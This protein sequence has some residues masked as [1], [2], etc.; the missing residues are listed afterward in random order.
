MKHN[1]LEQLALE[2]KRNLCPTVYKTYLPTTVPEPAEKR[3]PSLAGPISSQ[4]QP[5]HAKSSGGKKPRGED[6]KRGCDCTT[7]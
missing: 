1:G 7:F 6:K 2:G 5:M 3:K 4:T